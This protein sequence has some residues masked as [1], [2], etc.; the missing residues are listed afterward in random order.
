MGEPLNVGLVG[1]GN[2]SSQY[3]RTL[4]AVSNL[5]IVAVCDADRQRARDAAAMAPGSR[6][7]TLDELLAA[8]D[9][10]VVLNLTPPA[11]H[12]EVAL[13]AIAAG[14]HVYG[15][16]PL[17]TST[18]DAAAVVEAGKRAGL[19]VG[20]APDTVLGTGIQTARKAVEDGVIGRPTSA[21][22]VMGVFGHETWHPNPE[23]YYLPGG[24][25]LLDMG[26]YY[27]SAL[28]HL[29]GPVKS[30]M[31]AGSRPRPLRTIASGTR[32]GTTFTTSVDT[33]ITGILEHESGALTTLIMSF[34]VL[35]T[36]AS[37]IEVHGTAGS[38]VVPDPNLFD[39]DCKV[40]NP[41]DSAWRVLA[42]SAGFVGSSRGYGLAEMAEAIG[43]GRSH[44][45][46]AELAYHVLDCSHS[47]LEAANKRTTLDVSSRCE[48]P[49]LVPL[50][51]EAFGRASSRRLG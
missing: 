16:K 13:A 23:F 30:V 7:T 31:G 20:G 38:L 33:H 51:D 43:E 19:R 10:D 15:E 49:P 39:G 42:P 50:N 28:I 5:R 17:A 34:D 46:S 44:R 21:T 6:S 26:P 14:K 22:A 24:G 36:Q 45:A 47:L 12:A 8:G 32:A 4:G 37:S 35:A 11:A 9:V 25:P 3:L 2:I 48:V 29:L 1:A 40:R 27:L 41:G 18:A